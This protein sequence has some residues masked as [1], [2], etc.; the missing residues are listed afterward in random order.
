MIDGLAFKIFAGF[1]IVFCILL[2][3]WALAVFVLRSF[4]VMK[5]RGGLG[6]MVAAVVLTLWGGVKPQSSLGRLIFY[7][8]D[9]EIKWLTDNG[10]YVSNDVVHIEFE[11]HAQLPSTAILQMWNCPTNQTGEFSFWAQY[12]A[13]MTLAECP[14]VFDIA[15]PDAMAY[16]WMMMTTYVRPSQVV[17]NGVMHIN[18]IRPQKA[19]I[20]ITNAVLAVPIHTAVITNGVRLLL[21]D[22]IGRAAPATLDETETKEGELE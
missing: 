7:Q 19:E 14:R 22:R 10:S 5:F 4:R 3:V 8:T 16:A 9:P 1:T 6:L 11:P 21:F 15:F 13:D 17:T 2:A 20:A 12:G 18:Y